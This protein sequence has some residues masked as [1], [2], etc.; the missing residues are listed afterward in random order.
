MQP[1]SGW[2]RSTAKQLTIDVLPTALAPCSSHHE[3]L[4]YVVR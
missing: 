1:A 2:F 4:T 3:Q